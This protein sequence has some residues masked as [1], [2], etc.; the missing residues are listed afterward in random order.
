MDVEGVKD[1][2]ADF[3]K[4]TAEVRYD[5]A[6]TSPNAIAKAISNATGFKASAPDPRKK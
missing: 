4:R 6:K 1:S 5:P 2:K 3:K